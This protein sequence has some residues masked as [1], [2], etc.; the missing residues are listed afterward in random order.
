MTA[1][2][3]LLLDGAGGVT[4]R[5]KTRAQKLDMQMNLMLYVGNLPAFA[6]AFDADGYDARFHMRAMGDNG[7]VPH[8]LVGGQWMWTVTLP[9]YPE[10]MWP[11]AIA[12][13]QTKFGATHWALHVVQPPEDLYHSVFSTAGVDWA[14]QTNKLKTLLEASGMIVV[15]AGVSTTQALCP[16]LNGAQA[17]VAMSDWDDWASADCQIDAMATAMPNAL[18]YWERPGPNPRIS[19]E[20]DGCSVVQ[21]NDGNGGEWLRCVIRRCPNFVGVLYE[22]NIWDGLQAA[23][24]EITRCHP[25]YR[26]VQEVD[27]ENNT[28][29]LFWQGGDPQAY[30]ALSDQLHAACPWI[31]GYGSG[32][33]PH[34][35][36]PDG[37]GGGGTL[38]PGDGFPFADAVQHLGTTFTGWPATAEITKL[39]LGTTGVSVEFTR[40]DGPG[41]WPDVPF[42]QPGDTLQYCL[43]IAMLIAGVWHVSAPIQY[44]YG[45]AE[46]GGNVGF[47]GLCDNGI[48]GQIHGNWFYDAVWGPLQR[49]PAVG[50]LVGFFVVAGNVRGYGLPDSIGVLERSNVVVVPFPDPS[51]A[52]FSI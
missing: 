8:G 6:P 49:Q 26:D 10:S 34:P 2:Q 38:Q 43:G 22:V 20:P 36:P 41:R 13:A 28:Y 40:R 30:I 37:G 1:G 3:F 4:P 35:P 5:T 9:L 44:W 23:I 7:S 29:I 45:L 42:G 46:A 32:A 25:F 47:Q 14:A 27:F 39:V 50:E 12:Q 48:A 17:Q 15:W 21:P 18:L 24:D 16:G 11:A 52:A 31:R 19:P 33:T 51:G